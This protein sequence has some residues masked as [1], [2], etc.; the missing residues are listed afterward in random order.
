LAPRELDDAVTGAAVRLASHVGREQR[1]LGAS[2]IDGDAQRQRCGGS[3]ASGRSVT[4][5]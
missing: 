1:Q 3:T 4:R 2:R 5:P